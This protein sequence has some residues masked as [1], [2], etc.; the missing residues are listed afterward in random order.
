MIE[1]KTF[2]GISCIRHGFF[3]RT[4]GR[5]DGLY[6]SLNC[7][8]GSE[9]N[10]KAV[11]ANRTICAEAL[12]VAAQSLLTVQ[13]EHTADVVTV[14]GPWTIERAP[15]ADGLVTNMPNIA[16]AVLA[17]DCTPVL[18]VDPGARII[19]AAHAGWKGAITGVIENT[20]EVMTDLGAARD[21]IRVAIGPC[22]GAASYEVGPEFRDRFITKNQQNTR[23][24]KPSPRDGHTYFDIGGFT[25]DCAKAA[26]VLSIDRIDA[27]TCKD[28]GR[29]FSYRRSCHKGEPDYGR[30]LSGIALVP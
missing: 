27:D 12:G 25:S 20:I 26:G 18:F 5:S 21:N 17:A 13:Q 23:Y 15:V 2:A 7:G 8:L 16:L 29:F 19:G 30:Q 1:A 6:S 11:V 10:R 28:E 4:G 9:D 22:I 3:T 14:K 24:F